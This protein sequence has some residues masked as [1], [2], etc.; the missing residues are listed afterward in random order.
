[1][2]LREYDTHELS[3]LDREIFEEVLRL[4]RDCNKW[5]EVYDLA[6]RV[7]SSSLKSMVLHTANVMRNTLDFYEENDLGE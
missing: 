7:Q 5:K 2:R 4:N 1:M 6:G 3:Q